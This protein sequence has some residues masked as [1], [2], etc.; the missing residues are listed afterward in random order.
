MAPSAL[1][2]IRCW[3]F[4]IEAQ[5]L[6]PKI[7]DK[8]SENL[9]ILHYFAQEHWLRRYELND[10][11]EKSGSLQGFQCSLPPTTLSVSRVW[12]PVLSRS[13]IVFLS[14]YRLCITSLE[15]PNSKLW[16]LMTI[17]NCILWNV[18]NTSK[19]MAH[20]FITQLRTFCLH[21]AREKSIT[22]TTWVWQKWLET[23]N[24]VTTMIKLF[25]ERWLL[26]DNFQESIHFR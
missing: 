23:C 22:M 6:F 9:S 4:Y 16:Q 5:E 14:F 20:G 10:W 3:C 13:I 2:D 11:T 25:P 8:K 1:S 17:A 21:N 26:N 7:C 15:R 24:N 18:N 19:F 12:S